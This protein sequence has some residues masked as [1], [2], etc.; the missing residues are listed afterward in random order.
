MYT[1]DNVANTDNDNDTAWLHKHKLAKS[2]VL[3][4]QGH[5]II[6]KW[7]LLKNQVF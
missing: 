1:K 6:P 4:V 3:N 5:Y 2:E 7:K